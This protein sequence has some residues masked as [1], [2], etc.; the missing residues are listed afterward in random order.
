M[1]LLLLLLLL[2]YSFNF[3]D[4]L[5]HPYR[6]ILQQANANA[7]LW[8]HWALSPTS[9]FKRYILEAFVVHGPAGAEDLDCLK[10]PTE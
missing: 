10:Q 3:Q 6:C 9:S 1:L 8:Q 2:L 7:N 4:F 5:M